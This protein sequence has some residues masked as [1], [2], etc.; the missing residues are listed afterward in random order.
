M[1]KAGHGRLFDLALAAPTYA[2][3]RGDL[4]AVIRAIESESGPERQ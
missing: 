4:A 2:K 1:L 3:D